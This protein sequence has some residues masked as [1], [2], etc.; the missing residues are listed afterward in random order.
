M[1]VMTTRCNPV[2]Q[3]ADLQIFTFA[4]ND[5]NV[6]RSFIIHQL[7]VK[8]ISHTRDL[9]MQ[10]LLTATEELTKR[11]E[12]LEFQNSNL[13]IRLKNVEQLKDIGSRGGVHVS[14]E[15]GQYGNTGKPKEAV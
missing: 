7:T 13:I 1:L 14:S 3:R 2:L 5:L 6:R 12:M 10:R 11:V 8:E 9:D 15:V 4:D